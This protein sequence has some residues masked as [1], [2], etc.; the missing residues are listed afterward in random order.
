MES[1]PLAKAGL[2]KSTTSTAK[3]E[4]RANSDLTKESLNTAMKSKPKPKTKPKRKEVNTPE[5]TTLRKTKKRQRDY[6]Y[7]PKSK[8][9]QHRGKGKDI[10]PLSN[11]AHPHEV[12]SARTPTNDS[13]GQASPKKAKALGTSAKVGQKTVGTKPQRPSRK[14]S[15]G[16]SRIGTPTRSSVQTKRKTK[17]QKKKKNPT[18]KQTTTGIITNTSNNQTTAIPQATAKTSSSTTTTISNVNANLNSHNVNHTQKSKSI[19]KQ[20]RRSKDKN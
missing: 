18:T 19:V 8:Q 5:G 11:F 17:P 1:Q 3:I 13:T 6:D 15:G 7:E 20:D 10:K 9:N 4:A 2:H 16:R 14:D 12:V